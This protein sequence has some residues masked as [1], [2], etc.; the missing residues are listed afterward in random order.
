MRPHDPD[1]ARI[2]IGTMLSEVWR[3]KWRIAGVTIALM[4]LTYIALLFVPKLYESSASLLV[5]SRDTTFTKAS[6]VTSSSSGGGGGDAMAIASQVELIQS[7]DTLLPVIDRLDL[8][9]VPEFNTASPG[10]VGSLLGLIGRAPPPPKD[11]TATVLANLEKRLTVIRERDSR[12]ISIL[13]RSE[14]P[15]LAAR[16]ANAIAA[17]HVSRSAGLEVSDTADASKW[18]ETEIDKMR[19]K[20]AAADAAVANFRIKNDLYKGKDGTSSLVE[21][22][23]SDIA[24]QITQSEERESTARSRSAVLRSLI[25]QGKPIDSVPAVRDS[26]VIAALAKQ[27][28]ELQGKK[29]ELL[30]RLLPSHPSVE[31]ATAQ[32]REIDK[33]MIAEGR[34]IADALASEADIEA[35]IQRSMQD[36]LTQLKATASTDLTN[37]VS[38]SEL[39]REA[40]AQRDLL[41]NYLVRYRDASARTDITSALPDVRIVSEAAPS[42]VPASP[43]TSLIL[44]AVLV[45]SLAGQV[46]YILFA[47]LASG[48]A[49]I[50]GRDEWDEA[51]DDT[52]RDAE[53]PSRFAAAG[54]REQEPAPPED[55]EMAEHPMTGSPEEPRLDVYPADE[56]GTGAYLDEAAD[57]GEAV[58]ENEETEPAHAPKI[59]SRFADLLRRSPRRPRSQPANDDLDGD[60]VDGGEDPLNASRSTI[61]Y[62]EAIEPVTAEA[63]EP[64][65]PPQ[66]PRIEPRQTP[67]SDLA[68]HMLADDERGGQPE[69]NRGR[70]P[71]DWAAHMAAD[72]ERA[73][74]PEAKPAA[75]PSDWPARMVADEESDEQT[76]ASPVTPAPTVAEPVVES[77][78]QVPAPEADVGEA[79]VSVAVPERGIDRAD[80][81][82]L[83]SD[84][85]HAAFEPVAPSAP[86]ASFAATPARSA[87]RPSEPSPVQPPASNQVRQTGYVSRQQGG[88]APRRPQARRLPESLKPLVNAIVTGRER[89]VLVSALGDPAF[90]AGVVEQ[91]GAA[92]SALGLGVATID[93]ASAR[94]GDTAGLGDLLAGAASFGDVVH[95]DH[96]GHL[97]RVPWGRKNKLDSRSSQGVTLAEALSDIYNVVLVSTGV[98]GPG[99]SLPVF[100]GL[101]GYVLLA[102]THA[103][104]ESVLSG[105]E[106]GA[107]ALGFKRVQVVSA[108]DGDMQVA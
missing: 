46:G 68:V 1:T 34:R 44:I 94:V 25:Q 102:S 41:E 40:K 71:S 19:A 36:K 27:R 82:A 65:L 108:E 53:T 39:E 100:A 50:A 49:V 3:R 95:A 96:G 79:D 90:S 20:V 78:A 58:D 73:G 2:D 35:G 37:G 63:Y 77:K 55:D 69:T 91:I 7:R 97:A 88:A 80:E 52:P 70:P 74:Q 16:I 8:K 104:D 12:V 85:Q 83:A 59:V 76:D 60:D 57:A 64:S 17:A 31:A 23:L 14:D 4:A 81:P 86:R 13:F 43:K 28:S 103:V 75:P 105:F 6:T 107:A 72:E 38:L 66:E 10:I 48:R 29:A 32:I 5:G 22:Q 92:C 56:A 21:Q 9:N 15:V 62:A 84:G 30:A 54:V 26:A 42:Y 45:V 87:G 89:V 24:S 93:A 101:D 99:S 67:P 98:P 61:G 47:E 51:E 106:A 18:L 11:V 33:Q